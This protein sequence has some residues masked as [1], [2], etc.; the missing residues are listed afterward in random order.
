MCFP[1]AFWWAV[2]RIREMHM[3]WLA[4]GVETGAGMMVSTGTEVL[5][6]LVL[7]AGGVTSR[8]Q[9]KGGGGGRRR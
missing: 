3:G 7:V 6:A 8:Y 4:L 1:V 5:V 2:E 9:G